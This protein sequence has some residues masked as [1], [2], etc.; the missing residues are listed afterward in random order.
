MCNLLTDWNK[1]FSSAPSP[2]SNSLLLG[3]VSSPSSSYFLSLLYDTLCLVPA[4]AYQ[5]Q[6]PHAAKWQQQHKPGMTAPTVS[7]EPGRIF[8]T[9]KA[10]ARGK[11]KTKLEQLP[12]NWMNLCGNTTR[13][14]SIPALAPCSQL[15]SPKTC[16]GA[17][18]GLHA[19]AFKPQWN[20]PESFGKTCSVAFEGCKR[21][22]ILSQ[23]KR[24][25]ALYTRT[26]KVAEL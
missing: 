16:P 6:K 18:P 14:E 17:Y 7:L 2:F 10:P 5:W 15:S 11:A 12:V 8:W 3:R 22:E 24:E 25:L 23:L 1:S 9:Y 21:E 4:S 26:L 19:A 13:V 20:T